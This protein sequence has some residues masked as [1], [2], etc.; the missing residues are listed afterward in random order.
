MAFPLELA[1]NFGWLNGAGTLAL[2]QP[3]S[4][5]SVL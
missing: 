4:C 2:V 1:R 5:V 3:N